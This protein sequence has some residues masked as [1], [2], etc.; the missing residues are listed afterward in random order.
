[1]QSAD[2][3]QVTELQNCFDVVKMQQQLKGGQRTI[4]LI[5]LFIKYGYEIRQICK[6]PFR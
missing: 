5:S 6:I 4:D 2:L 1:M 3:K